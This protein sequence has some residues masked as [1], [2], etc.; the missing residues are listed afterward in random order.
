M[1]ER[2]TKF[3]CSSPLRVRIKS[4]KN[5]RISNDTLLHNFLIYFFSQYNR[6]FCVTYCIRDVSL[7]F[8]LLN[9]LFI[10]CYKKE[11][12]L[13]ITFIIIIF[14]SWLCNFLSA[15]LIEFYDQYFRLNPRLLKFM[16]FYY[17]NNIIHI[18]LNMGRC[19][20]T[21][22][23]GA[24]IEVSTKLCISMEFYSANIEQSLTFI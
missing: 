20:H 21:Q 24:I 8:G 12:V 18:I 13:N 10:V 9:F 1:W 19:L 11:R 3:N 2:Q 7:A 14:H 5:L 23:L 22:N 15:T 16:N 6:N 4:N 17:F